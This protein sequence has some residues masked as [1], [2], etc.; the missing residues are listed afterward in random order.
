MVLSSEDRY[1]KIVLSDDDVSIEPHLD[2]LSNDD[3]GDTKVIIHVIKT[4]KE[5]SEFVVTVWSPLGDN[6][7]VV[8]SN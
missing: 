4:L 8:F 5:D 1:T 3:E 6:D 2:L 7:I